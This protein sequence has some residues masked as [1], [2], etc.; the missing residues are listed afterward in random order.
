MRRSRITSTSKDWP[1]H[2]IGRW[3][4]KVDSTNTLP[5][6]DEWV[7]PCYYMC[8]LV[9]P[10]CFVD[11]T[12]YYCT[13][14]VSHVTLSAEKTRMPHDWRLDEHLQHRRSNVAA[15]LAVRNASLSFLQGD[16][17]Y[18]SNT[19]FAIAYWNT[20]VWNWNQCKY[21]KKFLTLLLDI[22]FLCSCISCLALLSS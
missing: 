5:V 13:S 9:Y 14:F 15:T 21:I 2:A 16:S 10:L 6:N 3:Y 17:L 4:E 12:M 19:C 20:F 11:L 18:A 8:D 22:Y 7:L 1:V